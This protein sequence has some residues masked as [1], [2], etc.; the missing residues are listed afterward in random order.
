MDS[1]QFLDNE[2]IVGKKLDDLMWYGYPEIR[3]A[4]TK[5]PDLST[6]SLATEIP[7]DWS[8]D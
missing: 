3:E 8:W 7:T 2:S 1:A 4:M 6:L 5:D